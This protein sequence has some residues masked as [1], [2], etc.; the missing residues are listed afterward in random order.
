MILGIFEVIKFLEGNFNSFMCGDGHAIVSRSSF[1]L[2]SLNSI[3]A[4]PLKFHKYL[5]KNVSTSLIIEYSQRHFFD[6]ILPIICRNS[7]ITLK[8]FKYTYFTWFAVNVSFLSLREINAFEKTK[9]YA[10]LPRN[11]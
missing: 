7:I 8:D 1:K 2:I 9:Y 11:M 10:T 4:C 3:K 5:R 6:F